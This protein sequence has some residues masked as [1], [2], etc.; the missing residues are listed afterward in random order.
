MLKSFVNLGQLLSILV[1]PQTSN[2]IQEEKPELFHFL[3][4]VASEELDKLD[5]WDSDDISDESDVDETMIQIPRISS[6]L[7]LGPKKTIKKVSPKTST[8]K[9]SKCRGITRSDKISFARWRWGKQ[10]LAKDGSVI[11]TEEEID[12]TPVLRSTQCLEYLVIRNTGRPSTM[13]RKCYEI[14]RT[15]Q[16]GLRDMKRG[17]LGKK[18]VFSPDTLLSH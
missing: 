14:N 11:A 13:C 12:D 15:L 16:Y 10:V 1:Q 4:V 17:K 8:K 2:I 9:T 5:A 6:D 18:K 7:F 3:K